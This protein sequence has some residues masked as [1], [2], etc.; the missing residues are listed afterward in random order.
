M[1]NE[2]K[3][4]VERSRALLGFDLT[5][6]L[7]KQVFSDIDP[8]KKGFITLSDWVLTFNGFNW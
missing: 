5:D 7:V 1:F 8:H 2:F 6:D 4:Y 3:T